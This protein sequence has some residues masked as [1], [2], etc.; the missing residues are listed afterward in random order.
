[1]TTK[2]IQTKSA[3]YYVPRNKVLN[4]DFKDFFLIN[5][6]QTQIWYGK[7]IITQY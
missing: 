3:G 5:T 1:M 4:A 7:F 6:K 2:Q